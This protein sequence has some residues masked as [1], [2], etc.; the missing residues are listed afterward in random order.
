MDVTIVVNKTGEWIILVHTSNINWEGIME[1]ADVSMAT[2]I[3]RQA[4]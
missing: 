3:V 2:F 1:I 4:S